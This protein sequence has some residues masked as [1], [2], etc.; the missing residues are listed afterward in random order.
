MP[1]I[2]CSST[3]A[4]LAQSGHLILIGLGIVALLLLIRLLV[5]LNT[6]ADDAEVVTGSVRNV[7]DSV[8]A[9]ADTLRK[10]GDTVTSFVGVK[11]KRK[12]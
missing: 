6:V 4:V 12:K 9:G 2:Y 10:I 8:I 3:Y 11:K 1:H 7:F 5:R